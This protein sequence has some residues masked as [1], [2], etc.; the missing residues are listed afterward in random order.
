MSYVQPLANGIRT[1]HPVPGLPFVEDE[2][3]PI[4]DPDAVEAIGRHEEAGTWGR[5]DNNHETGEWVAFTTD[6]KNPSVGWVVRYHPDHGRSV[7]LYRE[8]DTTSAYSQWFNDRPLLSRLGG[9]WWNGTTWYRPGQIIDWASERLVRREARLPTVITAADLLDDTG[10]AELGRPA[11]I[12][13]LG[14]EHNRT[15]LAGYQL[16]STT[17]GQL[18]QGEQWRHDL[19]LWAS[20]RNDDALPL[21]RC[22]VTVNAPELFDAALLG[23]DEFAAKAEIAASTLRAYI[24]RAEADIPCPQATD[25][26]RKRWA[27]PVVEDWIEQR[28]RDPEKVAALLNTSSGGDGDDSED[29]LAPGLR[30]LWKRLADVFVNEL[31]RDAAA[32]RRW[33]RPHRNEQA[34]ANLS[35]QLGWIAALHLDSTVPFEALTAV[36]QDSVMWQIK[37]YQET[38]QLDPDREVYFDQQLGMMLG[39]FVEHRPSRVTNMFGLM[40]GN[41][42][43]LL[44]TPRE[45]TTR[46]LRRAIRMDGGFGEKTD[47]LDE[48]LDRV[49]PPTR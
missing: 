37:S 16:H 15:E 10:R 49:S 13:Q 24:A 22:V 39:W 19:A 34:V 23:V 41:A 3:I 12:M 25:G 8:P 33:S 29:T 46:A 18:T 7:L 32:R 28:R 21:T 11:R 20:R 31:W 43:R 36:L 5:C 1:D 9:Y 42:E 38:D 14:G 2:H 45:I 4:D 6:P 35:N 17:T 26:P 27:R 30:T 44:G 48:F 47:Q 40:I